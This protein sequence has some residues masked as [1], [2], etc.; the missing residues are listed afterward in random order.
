MQISDSIE[1]SLTI[2]KIVAVNFRT[3]EVFKKYGIDFCCK[4]NRLLVDVCREKNL[5][6]AAIEDE[7]LRV[8]EASQSIPEDQ[9]RSMPLDELV[10][11][12]QSKHHTY[13]RQSIP[14]LLGYLNKINKVHGDRHP[15]L[16][17]IYQ[18]FDACATELTHHMVKEETILF[19][20]IIKIAEADRKGHAIQPFFF[21][22][23]QNPINMMEH[24]HT[25]EGDRLFRI[26]ALSNNFTAPADGCT[27]YNVAFQKLQEFQDDLFLHIHLE[28]NIL[29]PKSIEL[30]KVIVIR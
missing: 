13:V 27:T 29:F 4:G 8:M 2:G 25:V 7:V 10:T 24:E 5:D 11:H 3:A 16:D 20:A 22:S 12:I 23:L 30:E 9:Y 15:E 26:A 1:S 19:P 18:L 28:N 21:G 6:F 17:E 14:V